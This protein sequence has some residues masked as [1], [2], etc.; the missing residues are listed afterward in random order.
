ML[1]RAL[2]RMPVLGLQG[3]LD[4]FARNRELER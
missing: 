4:L 3:V 1:I 2:E